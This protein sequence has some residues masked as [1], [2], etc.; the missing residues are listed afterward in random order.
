MKYLKSF[1]LMSVLLMFSIS[2]LVYARGKTPSALDKPEEGL[3][4][5]FVTNQSSDI[6]EIKIYDFDNEK[7][8]YKNI[9][10]NPWPDDNSSFAT[11]LKLGTYYL[12]TKKIDANIDEIAGIRF[13]LDENYVNN[14]LGPL[15][16][17][18]SD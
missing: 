8:I 5:I 16:I 3:Y 11:H 18:I 15:F 13:V 2:S 6:Q 1:L 12:I 17:E 10:L 14:A 9:F 4:Y 7:F